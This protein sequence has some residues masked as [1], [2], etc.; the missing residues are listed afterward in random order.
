MSIKNFRDLRHKLGHRGESDAVKILKCKKYRI[1]GRNWKIKA[2]EI[3]I[4]ALDGDNVVFVE[5][6]SKCIR[7]ENDVFNHI[8]NFSNRQRKRNFAAAK[9]FR[10]VSGTTALPGRFDLMEMKYDQSM[11]LIGAY[12]HYD[13]LP[14]L[15]PEEQK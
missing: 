1:L 15:L 14:P 13:Y 6:K 10:K 11:R 4:V 9:V 12:Q 8:L 7:N 2:G 5:V 3:D